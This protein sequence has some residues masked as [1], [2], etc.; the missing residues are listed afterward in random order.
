MQYGANPDPQSSMKTISGGRRV[1]ESIALIMIYAN[2][3]FIIWVCMCGM[4]SSLTSTFGSGC[5]E[6]YLP[7]RSE[8]S[9]CLFSMQERKVLRVELG[10]KT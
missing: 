9:R 8:V 2:L 10:I 7:L 4:A 5:C 6:R 3:C 1:I